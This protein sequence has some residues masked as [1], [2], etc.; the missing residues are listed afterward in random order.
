MLIGDQ[1]RKSEKFG[2]RYNLKYT[3]NTIFIAFNKKGVIS[4]EKNSS[5]IFKALVV[6]QFNSRGF[7]L[8]HI[9][10]MK[11]FIYYY[12]FIIYLE[13][14]NFLAMHSERANFQYRG[15]LYHKINIEFFSRHFISPNIFLMFFLYFL[16][17]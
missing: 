15:L 1:C 7:L 17:A 5:S 13:H 6:A 2:D 8:Y 16:G 10:Y 3:L 9:I 14:S 11:K 4:V 12:I